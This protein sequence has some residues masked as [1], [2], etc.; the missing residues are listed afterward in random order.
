MAYATQKQLRR[1]VAMRLGVTEPDAQR[2]I[3]INAEVL[4]EAVRR[5]GYVSIPRLGYVFRDK[6]KGRRWWTKCV[7]S[8]KLWK[9]G[10]RNEEE[11]RRRRIRMRKHG[12]DP[13]EVE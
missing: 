10:E 9:L 12:Y 11:K 7:L 13:D 8:D 3:E 6:V 5:D 1:A 2:L 4:I